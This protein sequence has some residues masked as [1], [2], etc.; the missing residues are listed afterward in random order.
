MKC[1]TQ[2]GFID[3]LCVDALPVQIYSQGTY[4]YYIDVFGHGST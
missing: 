3:S 2:E 1:V 4:Y